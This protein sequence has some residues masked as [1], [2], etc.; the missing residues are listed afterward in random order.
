GRTA[1][2]MQA[3]VCFLMADQIPLAVQTLSR[4]RQLKASAVSDKAA[5]MLKELAA[6]SPDAASA[7]D[8]G[9]SS[10]VEAVFDVGEKVRTLIGDLLSPQTRLIIQ[11][12]PALLTETLTA[13]DDEINNPKLD[14]R[15]ISTES[16]YGIYLKELGDRRIS[17]T[18][19]P[20][21]PDPAGA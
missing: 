6:I 1:T 21:V 12:A 5:A 15:F 17:E 9:T 11:P 3:A 19:R 4:L 20:P 10:D 16:Q 18:E 2:G 13:R 14:M 7:A 8:T